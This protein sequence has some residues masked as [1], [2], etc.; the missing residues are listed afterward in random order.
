MTEEH[1]PEGKPWSP[2][3]EGEPLLNAFGNPLTQTGDP[4]NPV[5]LPELE[6]GA[7]ELLGDEAVARETIR[8]AEVTQPAEPAK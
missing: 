5:A 3:I 2:T 4:A 7:E 1:K 6:V 8:P